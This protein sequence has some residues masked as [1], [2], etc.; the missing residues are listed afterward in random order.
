MVVVTI[1]AYS[2]YYF[3]VVGL[4]DTAEFYLFEDA[5]EY[6]H[7]GIDIQTNFRFVSKDLSLLNE[8]IVFD[9]NALLSPNEVTYRQDSSFDRYFLKFQITKE[10]TPVYVVHSFKHEDSQD[11]RFTLLLTAI[12]CVA[13]YL[14][15]LIVT[16]LNVKRFTRRFIYAVTSH[17][18]VED[19]QIKEYA[20]AHQL[21]YQSNKEKQLANTRER[22]F[23]TFLSHEI[24]QPLTVLGHAVSRLEQIDDIPLAALPIIKEVSNSRLTLIQLAEAILY[25]WQAPNETFTQAPI[26]ELLISWHREN[27]VTTELHTHEPTL[28]LPVDTYQFQLLLK[29]VT[30]NFMKYGKG[31][32]TLTIT[33]HEFA[34][35]NEC[36]AFRQVENSYGIGHFILEALARRFHLKLK[37]DNGKKRYC[38]KF[39]Q[40]NSE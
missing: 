9:Q 37:I 19:L 13:V 18:E 24:R 12:L 7:S 3:Y 8:P 2:G 22:N 29:V 16:V 11:I 35:T 33:S 17:N 28:T 4:D 31:K 20:Q 39:M 21:I 23:A 5:Y 1:L 36:N 6:Q 34:F 26:N 38:V 10:S 27:E 15:W 40:Q 14:I 30:D 32:L 25:L